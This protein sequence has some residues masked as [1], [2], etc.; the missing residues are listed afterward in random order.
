MIIWRKREGG[1]DENWVGEAFLSASCG[2]PGN[3]HGLIADGSYLIDRVM[4]SFFVVYHAPAGDP[5]K[6]VV[7]ITRSIQTLGWARVVA[8][9]H[10]QDRAL[11]REKM[12]RARYEEAKAQRQRSSRADDEDDYAPG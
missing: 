8:H 5:A 11:V 9:E 6:P 2:I 4:G 12:L 3:G 1:T 10:H 7:W